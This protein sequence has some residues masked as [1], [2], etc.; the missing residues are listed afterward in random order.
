MLPATNLPP[1]RSLPGIALCVLGLFLFSVQDVIIKYFSD[2]Y[3]VVQLVFVRS[4]VSLI[5]IFIIV[6]LVSGRRGLIPHKPK[7]MLTRGFLS[8]AAYLTY[9]MAIAALPL[10]DVVVIVFSAPIMVTVMSAMLLREQVGVRRWVVLFI[11]FLG[12]IIVVGPNGDFR[13]LATLLALLAAFT[14]AMSTVLTRIIGVEDKPWTIT[15]YAMFAF[16]IGSIVA[17]VLVAVF[18]AQSTT[19]NPALQFLLRPWV[20]PPIRD[21]LLMVFL[22]LNSAFALYCIIKAYW[23]APASVVAP[24]E[25][26]Y[27]IWA[28]LFGL[29][30]WAEVP[31]TN[32]LLG[33]TLLIGCGFYLVRHELQQNKANYR[34]LRP[35]LR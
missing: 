4:V 7:L 29:V 20:M 16:V 33:V 21:G 13:H 35:K 6:L 15:L 32:S 30:I 18:G 11:G 17:S 3:S 27:L 12:V 23:S 8:F 31:R 26:T 34:A 9:Y 22:G 14:Y 1:E 2:T 10:V 25:Y 19:D 28:V 5:P 24:F